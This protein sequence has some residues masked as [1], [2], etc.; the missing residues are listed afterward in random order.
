VVLLMVVLIAGEVP[1]AFLYQSVS[2]RADRL[3]GTVNRLSLANDQL[4]ATVA[5]QTNVIDSQAASLDRLVALAEYFRQQTTARGGSSPPPV[6]APPVSPAPAA[7]S[8]DSA[9]SGHVADGRAPAST[10]TTVAL[11]PLPNPCRSILKVVEVC[12]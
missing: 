7:G 12:S 6:L 2:R 10:T 8:S 11:P 4:Q 1:Q 9:T 5:N 3:T